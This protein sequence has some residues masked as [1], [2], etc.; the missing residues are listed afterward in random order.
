MNKITMKAMAALVLGLGLFTACSSNDE[1]EQGGTTT[2]GSTYMSVA[3]NLSTAN[4]SRADNQE[5]QNGNPE[6]NYVGKWAGQDKIEKIAVYVFNGNDLEASPEFSSSQFQ[7]QA[8]DP[9]TNQVKITP[10]KGI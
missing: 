9:A 10:L 4:G 3:I 1:P 7:V 5:D 2:G 6:N 8:A